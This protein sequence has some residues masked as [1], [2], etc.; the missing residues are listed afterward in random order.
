MK[1]SLNNKWGEAVAL[2]GLIIGLIVPGVEASPSTP[3]AT[4][5][6]FTVTNVIPN[7]SLTYTGTNS[8]IIDASSSQQLV[9]QETGT[10]GIQGATNV[11]TYY[12]SLD[13]ITWDTNAAD[14]LVLSNIIAPS[15]YSNTVCAKFTV[16]GTLTYRLGSTLTTVNALSVNFT[17]GVHNYSIKALLP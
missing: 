4:Y 2:A 5:Q 3:V 11:E 7:G 6:T 12:P 15:A 9:I 14:C 1:N 8:P 16:G 13:S 17:N 10:T